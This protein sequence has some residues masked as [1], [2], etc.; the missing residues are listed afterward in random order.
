MDKAVPLLRRVMEGWE[1]IGGFEHRL[2]I[3][4]VKDLGIA[5]AKLG[6]YEEG[7]ELLRWAIG[8]YRL[9]DKKDD[10]LACT[11]ILGRILEDHSN[12]R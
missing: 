7:E 12:V 10:V 1:A 9:N 5:L 3:E 4:S 2:T 11:H 8:S 6:K